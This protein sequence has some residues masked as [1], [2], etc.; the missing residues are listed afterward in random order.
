M[1]FR[2]GSISFLVSAEVCAPQQPFLQISGTYGW[3]P[4]SEEMDVSSQEHMISGIILP[5]QT[6]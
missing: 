6:S 3:L 1:S 4:G 2:N 5:V